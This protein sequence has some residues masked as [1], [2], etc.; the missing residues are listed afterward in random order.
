MDVQ[1][2]TLEGEQESLGLVLLDLAK[3]IGGK[4]FLLTLIETLRETKPS[5]FLSEKRE[6]SYPHGMMT[7][8]KTLFHDNWKILLDSA[9]VRTKEGTILPPS[10]DKRHKKVLNMIKALKPLVFTITPYE[11]IQD[12]DVVITPFE[13]IDL[14]TIRI[15]PLFKALFIIPLPNVK[16]ML[17]QAKESTPSI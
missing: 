13:V 3:K 4:N 7:W 14:E 17:L 2:V 1:N 16:E 10:T 11:R 8:N 12:Q 6:L 15:T 5:L 9:K